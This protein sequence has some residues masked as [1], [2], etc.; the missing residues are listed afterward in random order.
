MGASCNAPDGRVNVPKEE[1]PLFFLWVAK[2]HSTDKTLKQ[3]NH[4]RGLWLQVSLTKLETPTLVW[5]DR[6][7]SLAAGSNRDSP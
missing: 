2:V 3:M 7:M 6:Q 1:Q 5:Q 4:H